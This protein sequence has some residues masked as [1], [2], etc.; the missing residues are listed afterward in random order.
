MSFEELQE[1][2][3]E[4]WDHGGI[5]IYCDCGNDNFVEPDSEGFCEYCKKKIPNPLIEAGMI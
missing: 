3:Q 2:M 5:T 1:L 4:E